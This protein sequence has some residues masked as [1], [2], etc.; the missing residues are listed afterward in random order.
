MSAL[1]P[2]VITEQAFT[3]R[4]ADTLR[5]TRRLPSSGDMAEWWQAS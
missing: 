4:Q 3:E 2:L 1:E 5:D